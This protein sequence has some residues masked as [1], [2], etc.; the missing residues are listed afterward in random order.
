MS[1]TGTRPMNAGELTEWIKKRA[2]AEGKNRP[3]RQIQDASEVTDRVRKQAA[4]KLPAEYNSANRNSAEFATEFFASNEYRSGTKASVNKTTA[5]I[6]C[7]EPLPNAGTK[8]NNAIVCTRPIRVH[9]NDVR[10][11]VPTNVTPRSGVRTLPTQIP[12][13]IIPSCNSG[14]GP[15]NLRG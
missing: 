5:D 10:C 9:Q 11:F 15:S 12:G 13:G 4:Y 8:T 2:V 1:F 3:A 14:L 7:C 6:T